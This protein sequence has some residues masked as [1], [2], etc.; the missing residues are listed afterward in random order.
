[1]EVKA[2]AKNISLSPKRIRP[3]V[4]A[5]RGLAVPEALTVLRFL[6]SPAAADIA[7]VIKSAAANAEN[8][9]QLD[10]DSLRVVD[11]R[12]DEGMK[13]RR[14]LPMPRGRAGLIHKRHSHIT[15]IVS[16]EEA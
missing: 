16:E 3:I 10:P 12:A 15:V 13:L 1:M 2:R 7:K 6:P 11:I 8:N 9:F 4:S 5:V 14:Y